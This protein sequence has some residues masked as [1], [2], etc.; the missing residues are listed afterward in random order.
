[1]DFHA[2]FRKAFGQKGGNPVETI[3]AELHKR[4]QE[5]ESASVRIGFIGEAGVGKSSLI[6]AM[7]GQPVAPVGA[8]TVAHNPEGEKYQHEAVTFVDLPGTGVPARPFKGY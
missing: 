2:L 7:L 3:I 4:R 8:T 6:N 5:L 1:M